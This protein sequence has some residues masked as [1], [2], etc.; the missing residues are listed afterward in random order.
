MNSIAP[1]TVD[2]D[3]TKGPDEFLCL[4]IDRVYQTK[5]LL[6]P[7]ADESGDVLN[8]SVL[9][10]SRAF[11]EIRELRN[12]TYCHDQSPGGLSMCPTIITPSNSKN[13]QG[14]RNFDPL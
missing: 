2:E 14:R 8:R 4:N 5:K 7:R 6:L 11:E 9:G 1:N 13:N 3:V 10:N 12:T